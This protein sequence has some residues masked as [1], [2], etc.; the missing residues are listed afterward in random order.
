M[1]RRLTFLIVLASV[2]LLFASCSS[3]PTPDI[4]S[5]KSAMDQ[6]VT[7]EA[8]TYAPADFQAAKE[9]YDEAQAAI[10]AENDKFSVFRDYQPIVAKLNQAKTEFVAAAESAKAEKER[11][12]QEAQQALADAEQALSSARDMLGKA[13]RGKG[14]KADLAAL[15][16]DLDAVSS[17]LG[18]ARELISAGKYMEAK[19]KIASAKSQAESVTSEVEQAMAARRGRRG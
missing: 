10:K 13:P 4:A 9:T 12:H 1:F 16:A 6:A 19:T 18:S 2:A 3:E 8:E 11:V 7:A 5:A 15:A 14:T 17:A